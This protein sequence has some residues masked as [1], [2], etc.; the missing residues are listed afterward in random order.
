MKALIC[1]NGKIEIVEKPVPVIEKNT[2]AII[3]VTLSSICTSDL[4]IIH[5]FVPLAK[6]GVVL[7]HEFAGEVVETGNGVKDFKKGDRV[8]VNCETFC[9][10]CDF[11]KKGFVNNCINGGWEL[12]CKIDGCQAEYVRVPYADNGLTKLPDNVSYENAL[13]VGDILSSGYWGAELCEITNGDTV[14]VIGAGPVGL[15]AMQ[16]AKILG[17]GKVIAVDI[18]KNRL[19]LAQK[20]GFADFIS[21]PENC[22]ESIKEITKYGADAVIEAAGGKNTF[23]LAYKIARPNAVVAL[24]AMYEKNQIL[25]LPEMYGKN[26]IFKTGGVDAVHCK[27]LVK[28]IAEGKITTDFL[29]THRF[30]FDN[31]KDAYK[32]FEEKSENCLKVAVQY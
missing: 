3:K 26:L 28:L 8:S 17:A 11:C 7:G 5:G 27:E 31:I 6:N 14:A 1:K 29:I 25:P 30:S 21:E 22:E 4:H 18:D 10:V 9:G 23:E 15:C 24:V 13:F 19:E 16:C 20:L 32:L 12:G 2:D